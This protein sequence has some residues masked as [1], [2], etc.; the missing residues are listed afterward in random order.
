MNSRLPWVPKVKD[1][2]GLEDLLQEG[3]VSSEPV[4]G[5]GGLGKEKTHRISLVTERWLD[6]N[7]DVTELLS[8]NK[9]GSDHQ[10]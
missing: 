9:Q 4:V 5:A 3:V 2:I 8:V 6:S 1:G 10:S 7:E